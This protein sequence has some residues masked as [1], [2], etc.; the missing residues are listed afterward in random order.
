VQIALLLDTSNSMDGLIAQAKSQLW[1]VVNDLA[2][3]HRDGQRPIIQVALYE[4]GN[5]NLSAAGNYIRQV[6]PFT[7]DL[8]LVSEKLF[9]LTTN[10]GEEYCGA[11]IGKAMRDL[12]WTSREDAYK[13]IFIA[14][15]EPFTQGPVPY[16]ETVAHAWRH[17]IHVNT[18][19]CGT[20]QEGS[21]TGWQSGAHVGGGRYV[22]I[23]SDAPVVAMKTPYDDEI[24]RLG[25]R[26]N[27]TFVPMG[28]KG[29]SSKRRAKDM[30]EKAEALAPAGAHIERSLYKASSQYGA[31]W[32]AVSAVSTGKVSVAHIPKQDLPVELKEKSTDEITAILK[33][34]EKE[35]TEIQKSLTDLQKKRQDYLV[36]EEKKQPAVTTLDKAMRDVVREQATHKNFSFKS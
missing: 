35:R 33:T 28:Q 11:V 21:S 16:Q 8:D 7:T 5:N 15:N 12:E 23:N 14:G 27:D 26:V 30:D 1:K 2:Y 25:S 9:G 18:I 36:R 3:C 34:K 29:F 6:S 22:S 17:D 10:G 32:D 24:N 4:Y 31:E 13:V 19:F 20:N